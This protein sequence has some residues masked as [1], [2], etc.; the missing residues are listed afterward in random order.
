MIG[1]SSRNPATCLWKSLIEVERGEGIALFCDRVHAFFVEGLGISSLSSSQQRQYGWHEYR[2]SFLKK[3][4]IYARSSVMN[5]F[6]EWGLSLSS[7][8]RTYKRWYKQKFTRVEVG[9][10]LSLLFI[11][12]HHIQ[13]IFQ[14]WLLKYLLTYELFLCFGDAHNFAFCTKIKSLP[15]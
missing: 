8:L 5:I 11:L 14:E 7:L 1:R 10:K 12:S 9:E 4:I 13:D 2:C 6:E 3:A 15:E